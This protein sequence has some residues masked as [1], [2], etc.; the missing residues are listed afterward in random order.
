MITEQLYFAYY[1]TNYHYNYSYNQ[2]IILKMRNNTGI[3][4]GSF[5]TNTTGKV[6]D[7]YKIIK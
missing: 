5:V 7:K 3:E 6:S 2:H 1:L 4:K